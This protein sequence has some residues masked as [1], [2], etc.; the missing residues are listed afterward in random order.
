MGCGGSTQKKD[1]AN[2]PANK[3]EA[4]EVQETNGYDEGGYGAGAYDDGRDDENE[5]RKVL[6]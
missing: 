1:N 5:Q 4:T 6:S 2:T 3:Y